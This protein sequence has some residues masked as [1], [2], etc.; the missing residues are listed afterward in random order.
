MAPVIQIPRA[1]VLQCTHPSLARVFTSKSVVLHA[2]PE[3]TA[4]LSLIIIARCSNCSSGLQSTNL[5][6]GPSQCWFDTHSCSGCRSL[7][8]FRDISLGSFLHNARR[9]GYLYVH[10]YV[11]RTSASSAP[12][13]PTWNVSFSIPRT[14]IC[15]T[16]LHNFIRK[17]R[18]L[19][20]E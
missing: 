16:A 19:E 8:T 10:M 14:F 5:V 12:C 15:L 18:G 6:L 2:F 7:P 9:C 3:A 4:L 17:R 1:K 11:F 13:T 20:Y